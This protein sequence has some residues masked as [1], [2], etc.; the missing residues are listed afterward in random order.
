VC[1]CVHVC[2][3]IYYVYIHAY[4]YID[5]AIANMFIVYGMRGGGRGGARILRNSGYRWAEALPWELAFTQYCY[6]QY[7]MV[8]GIQKGDRRGARI[9]LNSRAIVLQQCG[10]YRW[11]GRI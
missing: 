1:M 6:Y 10:Q 4:G 9:L 3:H 2:M 11:A 8:H 7:G 5:V